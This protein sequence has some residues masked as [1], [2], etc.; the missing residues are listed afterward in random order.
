MWRIQNRILITVDKPELFY[1]NTG[2]MSDH[3]ELNEKLPIDTKLSET[4]DDHNVQR[5][6]N[7]AGAKKVFT[8]SAAKVGPVKPNPVTSI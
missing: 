2:I 5:N 6:R 1:L 8:H 7:H 3:L 4:N